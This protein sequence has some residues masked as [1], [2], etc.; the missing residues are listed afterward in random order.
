MMAINTLHA[1]YI[2]IFSHFK[3]K[4]KILVFTVEITPTIATESNK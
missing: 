3:N 4:L 2:L 1:Y